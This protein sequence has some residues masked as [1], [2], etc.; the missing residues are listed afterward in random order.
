MQ[1]KLNPKND[2]I[3]RINSH[4]QEQYFDL[5]GYETVDPSEFDE[6]DGESIGVAF[7]FKKDDNNN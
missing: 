3:N 7:E 1:K 6:T 5:M 4:T 2:T